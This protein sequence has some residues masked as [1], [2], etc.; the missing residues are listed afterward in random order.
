VCL[1]CLPVSPTTH[2]SFYP[3][4]ESPKDAIFSSTVS[5]A[6]SERVVKT[7]VESYKDSK[8]SDITA[9]RNINEIEATRQWLVKYHSNIL[10]VLLNQGAPQDNVD[11]VS[12]LCK[13]ISVREVGRNEAVFTQGS[14]GNEI[15]FVLDGILLKTPS[16]CQTLLSNL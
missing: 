9:P 15:F 1:A 5:P 3:M 7:L 12:F 8:V 14:Q 11:F 10:Q 2:F 16:P 4:E 6:N 13:H